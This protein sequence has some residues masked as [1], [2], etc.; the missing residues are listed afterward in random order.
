M[1]KNLAIVIPAYK[2]DFFKSALDSLVA[3]TCKAF[4]V[5]IGDDCS[6]SD[7]RQLTDEY[8]DRLDIVYHRFDTN[9]GGKD[10]VGQWRRCIEMTN[11]EPWLWLFSDDD[12]IGPRCVELFYERIHSGSHYSDIFHFDVKIIDAQGNIVGN[13]TDYPHI[14]SSKDFFMKKESAKI[15]SFVV[16]YIFSREIYERVGG[17]E[18]FDLAWGSDIAT[19]VKMGLE[20]GIETI[21]GD[22]VYWRKSDKNITPNVNKEMVF[23]KFSINLQY[24]NWSNNFFDDEDIRRFNVYHLFR[25]V[26]HYGNILEL[27]QLSQLLNNAY[28]LNIITF[29]H[30]K[31]LYYSI[32]LLRIAKKIK[33]IV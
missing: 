15:D 5:Y 8:Q 16:E 17:F 14:I 29:M 4:T 9:M 10:L 19:W 11:N 27:N 33:D 20:K 28:R 24:I 25:L 22:N 13:T 18:N 23:R 3:Q 12:V 31:M 32:P 26:V 6:P 30:S 2:L 7:F 21:K 1:K